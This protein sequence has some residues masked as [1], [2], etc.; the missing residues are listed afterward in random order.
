MQLNRAIMAA[1]V[2]V[3]GLWGHSPALAAADTTLRVGIPASNPK[4]GTSTEEISTAQIDPVLVLTGLPANYTRDKA[5]SAFG[6]LVGLKN[7][8]K[9]ELSAALL[10]ASKVKKVTSLSLGINPVDAIFTQ[11]GTS[12]GAEVGRFTV[13]GSVDTTISIPLIC[14]TVKGNFELDNVRVQASYNAYTGNIGGANAFYNIK[15]TSVSCDNIIGDALIAFVSIF[16]DVDGPIKNEIDGFFDGISGSANSRTLFSV[17]AF[18]DGLKEFEKKNVLTNAATKGITAAQNLIEST[19]LNS[20]LQLNVSLFD[21]SSA[22]EIEFIASHQPVDV[23]H[24]EYTQS[25]IIVSLDVPGNTSAIDIYS[26]VNNRSSCAWVGNGS[27]SSAVIGTVDK[28]SEIIAIGRNG[29][30]GGLRSLPGRT[31]KTTWDF[32]CSGSECPIIY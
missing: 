24:L 17:E 18:L 21:G 22:N 9:N 28:G 15:S 1:S 19:N 2:A 3:F 25:N 13:T 27:G 23:T 10:S 26:C 5:N 31:K 4:N 11:Q 16:F 7:D 30:I 8:L 29:L 6:E 12:I 14:G 32:F 20:G